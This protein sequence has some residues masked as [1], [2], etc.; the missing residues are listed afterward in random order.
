MDGWN[1]RQSGLDQFCGYHKT[2]GYT[3]KRGV[4]YVANI[5]VIGDPMTTK[6]T[7]YLDCI[8]YTYGATA[9]NDPSADSIAT[10]YMHEIA[11]VI[12]DP[13]GNTWFNDITSYEIA[14]PCVFNFGDSF[15]YETANYNYQFGSKKYLVQTIFRSRLGCVS[16]Y[17]L[18]SLAKESP[19]L[20]SHKPDS[21]VVISILK[22][23]VKFYNIYLESIQYCIY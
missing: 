22:V 23:F 14:D 1:D 13:D 21:M 20:S 11:E 15:N 3:D 12:T 9:N 10:T 17:R 5:A 7:P 8:P 16:E 2:Y 6:P 4:S 19:I 18:P